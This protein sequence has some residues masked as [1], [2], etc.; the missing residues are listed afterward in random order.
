MRA[1]PGSAM[2]RGEEG[3]VAVLIRCLRLAAAPACAIM[4]LSIVVHD[5]GLPNAFCPAASG[6]WLSGMAPMYLMMSIYH[7]APWLKLM[8]RRGRVTLFARLDRSDDI[9]TM[10]QKPCS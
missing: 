4:A 7:S 6:S 2:G 8:S 9:Q 1:D 5:H 3:I 10:E